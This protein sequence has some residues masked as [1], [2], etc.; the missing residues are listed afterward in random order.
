VCA[1][2][3][4]AGRVLLA[5]EFSPERVKVDQDGLTNWQKAGLPTER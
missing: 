5:R 3:R 1:D 4:T 2:S